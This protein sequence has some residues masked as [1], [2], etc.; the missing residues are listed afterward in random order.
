MD[1]Y[2]RVRVRKY[3]SYTYFSGSGIAYSVLKEL[4]AA[5]SA[6]QN[7]AKAHRIFLYSETSRLALGSTQSAYRGSFPE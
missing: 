2:G 6:F 5:R 7:P 3:L 4:R 1:N